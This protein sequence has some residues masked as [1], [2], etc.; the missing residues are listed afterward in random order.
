M[1]MCYAREQRFVQTIAIRNC[2][3]CGRPARWTQ[4]GMDSPTGESEYLCGKC[5]DALAPEYR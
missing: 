1:T 3:V 5:Y 4:S 2:Q